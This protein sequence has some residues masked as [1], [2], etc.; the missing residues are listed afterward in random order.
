M[1]DRKIIIVDPVHPDQQTIKKAGKIIHQKGVVI[2]PAKCLYGVAVNAF[3]KTAVQKVFGLK[4]RESSKPLLVLIPDKSAV[5]QLV[6]AIPEQARKLMDAFWPG[7]LTLVFDAKDH[8]PSLLTA[9]TGKIGIRLPAQPVAKALVKACN[10]PITGTSANIS[11][12]Q[13]CS[14]IA[15]LDKNI[16][17]KSDLILDAGSLKGG[18]GSTVVDVTH[19]PPKILRQ[20]EISTQA[21]LQLVI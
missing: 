7:N 15:T 4:Q 12:Q 11:G 10:I 14:D 20:G 18:I 6:T 9:G 1:P 21:V 5:T 16:I 8:L 13:G 3:D 17:E 19:K 2:F